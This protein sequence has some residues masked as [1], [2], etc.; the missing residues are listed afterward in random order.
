M[1]EL[2]GNP[3]VMQD[4]R[5]IDPAASDKEV[6]TLLAENRYKLGFYDIVNGKEMHAATHE[7]SDQRW[8]LIK[9]TGDVT[10]R[11]LTLNGRV[12][13]G[14]VPNPSISNTAVG[15]VNRKRRIWQAII[16]A[17]MLL[18]ELTIFAVVL[19]YYLDGKS[20]PFN[21][22]FNSNRFG[23]RFVLTALALI[24]SAGWRTTSQEVTLMAPYRNMA[25]AFRNDTGVPGKRSI[26]AATA[27]TPFTAFHKGLVL[28]NYLIAAVAMSAVLSEVLLV[29]VS[30]VPFNTG[31]IK[32]SLQASTFVSL[33][34]LLIMALTTIAVMLHHRTSAG[35]TR[36]LPRSPNTLAGVW[37]YLCGS[38]L[39][40][41]DHRD[42]E[43]DGQSAP[44][45]NQEGL[46]ARYSSGNYGFACAVGVDGITRWTID[47]AAVLHS[48]RPETLQEKRDRQ[49]RPYQLDWPVGAAEGRPY[50]PS[51]YSSTG[52]NEP[53]GR[54]S[55]RPRSHEV[56][57]QD[58][59][60]RRRQQ[61][62]GD[63]KPQPSDSRTI[64]RKGL[65]GD[66]QDAAE[67]DLGER[68]P[69]RSGDESAEH[70]WWVTPK[71][72]TRF[73]DS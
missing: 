57:A 22:F 44:P 47:E 60:S 40:Q 14:A 54:S 11:S 67:H 23:P 28:R 56:N 18:T 35:G 50:T 19:A 20:D 6:A 70:G 27:C 66:K 10:S 45:L 71:R 59:D 43:E 64:Q 24:L 2:L 29:A 53:P 65:G 51:A 52:P 69:L 4:L 12:T 30:G 3:N 33:G 32:P 34:I 55:L 16:D 15:M 31:Q 62:Y 5:D 61:R 17:V 39:A 46:V 72:Q 73:R 63:E 9:L 25:R 36:R 7:G 37:I 48:S 13:Y 8:G 1:A 26:L 38:G 68:L 49:Q 58:N 41:H 42:G 21:D